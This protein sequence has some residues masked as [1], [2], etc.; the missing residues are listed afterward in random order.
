LQVVVSGIYLSE[1]PDPVG[2]EPVFG[3]KMLA[4]IGILGLCKDFTGGS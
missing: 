4:S 2:F 3:N 1:D